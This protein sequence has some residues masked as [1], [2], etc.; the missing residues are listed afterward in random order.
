MEFNIWGNDNH[1]VIGNNVQFNRGGNLWIEN[2][3]CELVIGDMTTFEEAHLAVT[4]DSSKIVI[5]NDCLFAYDIDV[6]TGDSHSIIEM[7]TGR[8]TNPPQD[9]IMGDHVWIAAHCSILRGS[10]IPSGSIVGTRSVVTRNSAGLD[11]NVL[12]CGSPA[13]VVREN[14]TWRRERI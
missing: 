3:H 7:G 11:G 13:S 10:R 14:V 8:R 2:N 4:E 12:L 1:I 5:G 9:V 6:R